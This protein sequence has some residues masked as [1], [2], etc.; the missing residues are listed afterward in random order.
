MRSFERRGFETELVTRTRSELTPWIN[1]LTRRLKLWLHDQLPV[2]RKQ[3][4][5]SEFFGAE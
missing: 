4:F 5:L 3:L 2:E 1:S